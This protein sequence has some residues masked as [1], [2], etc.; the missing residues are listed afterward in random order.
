[1]W[2][3]IT[4]SSRPVSEVPE[5]WTKLLD[6][7]AETSF[8][9]YRQ[10]IEHPA[11]GR[12]FRLATPITDIEQLQIASRPARRA[13]SDRIEDLRAI[14]WVF[15]WTQCRCLIPAWYGLG[16]ALGDHLQ[17]APDLIEEVRAMYGKWPFFRATIDNAVLA[18]AKSNRQ[19]FRRYAELA[20]EDPEC[21]EIAAMIESEWQSADESLRAVTDCAELLDDV[22]WLKRSIA[23]R[24]GY[25][26][27]LNLIQI[28][29]LRRGREEAAAPSADLADL[30][31]LVV[32][33][34][35]TGMRTTG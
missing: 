29:L 7:F 24:N 4:A 3:V 25:V 2:S 14:P 19:V 6:Q 5:N 18:V 32:K 22:P 30:R 26:D 13:E 34:V 31:Q 35:A 23:A 21:R 8:R 12:F 9:A 20:G 17:A 28:E 15:A 11:F 33:G 1:M 27:P 16:A 10:L